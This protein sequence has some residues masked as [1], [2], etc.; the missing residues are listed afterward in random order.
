MHRL[1]WRTPIHPM[2]CEQYPE[3]SP[4][5]VAG[6]RQPE[7]HS[8]PTLLDSGYL[9]GLSPATL[10]LCLSHTLTSFLSSN[11]PCLRPSPGLCTSCS[12]P[13]FCSLG[14]QRRYLPPQSGRSRALDLQRL[15]PLLALCFHGFQKF[16][17]F[18]KLLTI[19]VSSP[20]KRVK[21][22]MFLSQRAILLTVVHISPRTCHP[23]SARNRVTG[24]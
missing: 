11:T 10:F 4:Q 9:S 20:R 15:K 2:Q 19:T 5:D 3:I 12:P 7:Y 18:I 22:C 14:S 23:Q 13:A 8:R 16:F 21:G 6:R 17:L 24:P 1:P